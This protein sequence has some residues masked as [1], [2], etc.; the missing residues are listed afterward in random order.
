MLSLHDK[1]GKLAIR[2]NLY[3]AS[4]GYGWN[5]KPMENHDVKDSG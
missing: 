5:L 1:K 2:P 4:T 3:T